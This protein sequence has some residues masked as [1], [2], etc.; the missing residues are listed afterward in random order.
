MQAGCS[1][2]ISDAVGCAADFGDWERV[3]VIPV[4]SALHLAS[5][6]EDLAAYPRSFSWAADGLKNYSIDAAADALAAS[7]ME[8]SRT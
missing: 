2:V 4:G 7:I 1:V 8:L 6:L 5:A 3:R